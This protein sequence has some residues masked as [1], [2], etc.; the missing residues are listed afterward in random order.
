M[1]S[2]FTTTKLIISG[3]IFLMICVF[4]CIFDVQA[5]MLIQSNI[6]DDSARLQL[7]SIEN[8][9][10]Q[11]EFQLFYGSDPAHG[12]I[13]PQSVYDIQKPLSLSTSDILVLKCC[14]GSFLPVFIQ[15]G[16]LASGQ[17]EDGY[18]GPFYI[19]MWLHYPQVAES[20]KVHVRYAVAKGKI[21]SIGIKIGAKGDYRLVALQ[22]VTFIV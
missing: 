7:V 18:D 15:D 20:S 10:E 3:I 13:F 14:K 12:I 17:V 9:T 4:G 11:L 19:S 16:G 22:D 1:S 5:K 8:E 6:S 2:K 21:G